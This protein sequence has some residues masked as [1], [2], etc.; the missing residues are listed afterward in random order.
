MVR[1]ILHQDAVGLLCKCPSTSHRKPG[2]GEVHGE[3]KEHA[4]LLHVAKDAT[5]LRKPSNSAFHIHCPYSENP[6]RCHPGLS[7]RSYWGRMSSA[8]DTQPSIVTGSHDLLFAQICFFL[9]LCCSSCLVTSG[10]TKSLLGLCA[11][12]RNGTELTQ[13]PGQ[14]GVHLVFRNC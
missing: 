3:Y 13:R 7:A 12:L 11:G 2:T 5:A 1:I 4:S 10:K 6:G 8:P 14:E 9:T